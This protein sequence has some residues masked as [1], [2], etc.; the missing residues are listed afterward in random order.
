MGIS[1]EFLKKTKGN[2][3]EST[4]VNFHTIQAIYGS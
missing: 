4:A 3:N 1:N 2:S